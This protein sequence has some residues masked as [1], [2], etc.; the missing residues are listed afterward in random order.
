MPTFTDTVLQ[1]YPT[2]NKLLSALSHCNTSSAAL[3]VICSIYSP[4]YNESK[5]T[6][7]D[8]MNVEDALFQLII[9]MNKLASQPILM[10]K[11]LFDY[12]KFVSNVHRHAMPKIYLS[13]PFLW[14]MLK[15]LETNIALEVFCEMG[16]I[17]I[18]AENLVKSNRTLLN[19]QPNLVTMI[20]Q[21]LSKA[22]NIQAMTSQTTK[23]STTGSVKYDEGLINFAPYCTIT[24]ENPSAQPAD[25]LIQGQVSSHRRARAAAWSYLF[26]PNESHVDLILTLPTAVLLK[27]IQLQPHLSTLASCPSAVSIEISRDGMNLIPLTQPIM[28]SGM[29]CI[30]LKFP[31][32]EIATHLVIRLYRPKDSSTIGLSMISVLGT[33]IFNDG[34][35]NKSSISNLSSSSNNND[36]NNEEESQSEISFGWLRILA[37]CF[38]VATFNTDTNLSNMVIASASEVNGFMESCCSLLSIAPSM[39]NYL[40]QNLETVLLKLG[41]HNKD[42]S[43][44]LINILLN[45]SIPHIFKLCNETVSDILYLLCTT[46]DSFARDR[47]QM[48]IDWLMNLEESKQLENVN[49]NSGYIK[50][51]AS[52]LWQAYATNLVLDLGNLIKL[53]L[54]ER[55][56]S[57][58]ENISEYSP[59][60]LAIDSILCSICCIRPEFFNVLLRKMSVLVPIS[61]HGNKSA[62][63]SDDRKDNASATDDNKQFN[64]DAEEWYCNYTIQNLSSLNLTSSQMKTISMA[65]QSPLT[66]YQ[67]IDSGLPNLFTT[68][69]LEFCHRA[70]NQDVQCSSRCLTDADKALKNTYPMVNVKKITEIL[71]FMSDICAEEGHMRDWLGSYEGSMWIEP[72][73]TLLCNNK[74][75]GSYL[76]DD[77][78]NQ[79]FLELEETVIKFLSSFTS[80]HPKNQDILTTNLISVIRT[81]EKNNYNNINHQ[82]SSSSSSHPTI[83]SSSY[84]MKY[85]I[86]GF[87]RRLVLQILLESEKI[88]VSVRSEL[89]LLRKYDS[90]MTYISNH[91]S[92]KP[93]SH[94]L[95][96]YV[97]INTKCQEILQ[98]SISVFNNLL[99]SINSSDANSTRASSDF[100]LDNR[101]EKKDL[102][103][104]GMQ[105]NFGM[106]FLSVAAGVQAKDKRSKELKNQENAQRTKEFFNVFKMKPDEGKGLP[107]SIQF[108]HSACPEI[109]LTS[110]TT[111]SQ[112]LTMLKSNNI[113]LS[114]PCINLNLIQLKNNNS[115]VSD[116]SS[117]EIIKASDFNPLPSPL[118]IFSSR[119]G[120][121]L[122]AHYLP[123]VYPE[124]P[125]SIQK[126]SE[127]DKNLPGEWVKGEW[128]KIEPNEEIYEDVDDGIDSSCKMANVISSVPQHSLAAFG[129]FL[130]LPAYSE[131]LL[132]DKVRAQCLLRLILGVTGDGEGS[133]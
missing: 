84:N 46:S 21:H 18:L 121:S 69:I 64:N 75:Q 7:S 131:V 96:F 73:L 76:H 106:E 130:K 26:Y 107:D 72:L 85:S 34:N 23:K 63:L 56:Y 9:Y 109:A 116:E 15:I 90:N 24:S 112:I 52:I 49:P 25:V 22:Q 38:N 13:E 10:I 1:H 60:K 3:L 28:T 111:I 80:C 108:V 32:A 12:I 87:T 123:T 50:C 120:L 14:L 65:C 6:L 41:L 118:Q 83:S 42:L 59:M 19:T 45:E 133:K 100:P 53:E 81:T 71:N 40:L 114:T 31:Q 88:V 70:S 110:D 36:M 48:I 51:I 77:I 128:I 102:W 95:L 47:I 104:L 125:K 79:T 89:P 5:N 17:K 66:I 99:P 97:S 132:R 61:E 68:A 101:S 58:I 82:G 27:E 127:K 30:R 37:Q 11:P 92:K 57:W 44:K 105:M 86:S 78:N 8:P 16:G 103:D 29:T 124:Q 20:M 2:M 62:S 55:L 74:L 67:L 35:V 129:L 115:N 122:L 119:G 98:N 94:H 126:S 4:M 33:S 117:C 113:S 91:P 39:S 54:F 43:L 93:N